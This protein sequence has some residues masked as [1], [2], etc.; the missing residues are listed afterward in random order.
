MRNVTSD[1]T[2][3]DFHFMLVRRED[4]P[5][6]DKT[7]RMAQ[8]TGDKVDDLKDVDVFYHG[9]S[10]MNDRG[11]ELDALMANDTMVA[12]AGRLEGQR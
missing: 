3:K 2:L 6:T 10:L 12:Y 1:V 11:Y 8:I 7:R 5:V 9:Q 4:I